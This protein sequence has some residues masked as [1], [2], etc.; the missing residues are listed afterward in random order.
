MKTYK[1]VTNTGYAVKVLGDSLEFSSD[2]SI[3]FV[4]RG[5]GTVAVTPITSTVVEIKPNEE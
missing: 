4:N 5:G 3:V 1:I 2:G